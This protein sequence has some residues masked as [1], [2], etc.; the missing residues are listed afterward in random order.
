LLRV[1]DTAK[2]ASHEVA[3]VILH[4]M[5][6]QKTNRVGGRDGASPAGS[7][8]A[9]LRFASVLRTIPLPSL[10]RWWSSFYLAVAIRFVFT[11][12][13]TAQSVSSY[14][15]PKQFDSI[16]K[17]DVYTFV[18]SMPSYDKGETA[19][20]QR[21]AKNIR[22]PNDSSFQGSLT[23]GF[24]VDVDGVVYGA[25]V[26]DKREFEWSEIEKNIVESLKTTIWR[27]GY[28]DNEPVPVMMWLPINL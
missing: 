5:Q 11:T 25:R 14:D 27:P 20:V 13:V 26:K 7:G 15:C 24:V 23:I 17:K 9:R 3:F 1:N 18:T 6:T 21:L 28:C 22:Q 16:I 12:T 8:C 19:L 4:K 2:A 10:A